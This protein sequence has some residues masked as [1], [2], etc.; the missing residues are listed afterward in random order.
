M[1]QGLIRRAA[2]RAFSAGLPTRE[3]IECFGADG[4][5]AICR[6]LR[7][8]FDCVIR[9][10]VVPHKKKY[11]EKDLMVISKGV[12]F[13]IE[14]KNWKGVVRCEGDSF[15]QDKDNGVRK[16]LKSPIGTTEQF[17]LC[18]KSYYEITR[19]IY[20]IVVFAEPDCTLEIPAEMKGIALVKA[21]KL[22]SYIKDVVKNADK[23]LEPVEEYRMLRCTRFYSETEEFCKGM[24]VEDYLELVDENGREVLVDTTKIR[25]ITVESQRLRLRDKLY[26]T[27]TG[28]TSAVFYNRDVTVTV[29]CLDGSYRRIAINRVRHIVF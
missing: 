4:E 21:D 1:K 25:F 26:V 7:E 2:K 3:E 27:F 23:T 18:M 28:G 16:T 10:V 9:N 13:I 24:L 8:H 14:V 5:E 15:F 12:P 6:L 29:A 19:P 11:L 20:G 22:V 17:I